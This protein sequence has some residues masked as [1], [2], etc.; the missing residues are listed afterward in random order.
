M[1]SVVHHDKATSSSLKLVGSIISTTTNLPSICI[2][3]FLFSKNDSLTPL[4][5]KVRSAQLLPPL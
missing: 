1:K 2:A 5:H 4:E 3:L